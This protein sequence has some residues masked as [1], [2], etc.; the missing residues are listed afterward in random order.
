MRQGQAKGGSVRETLERICELQPQYSAEN[1]PEMQERGRLVRNN[2]R[3]EIDALRS[4]LTSALGPF[5]GDLLVEASDGIGRKTELPWVRFC[6]RNMSPNPTEGFYCV[7]H[8]STDGSAVH[9]T[10]GCGSSR[11]HKGSSVPLP[12]NELDAQ[13]DW[14]RRVVI[15]EFGTLV[16]FDHPADFGAR[17]PLPISF[18]RAT[19]ISHRVA[20]SDIRATDFGELFDQAALR[21]RP[22]Y[23]AQA[24]GR[25]LTDADQR[26]LEIATALNPLIRPSGRQGYGLSAPARRAVEKRAMEVASQF[27]H[28][29]GYAVRDTSGSSPF[30]F[31]ATLS[32]V[33]IKVEVKGTTSDRA[34]GILLTANE[35]ELHRTE[36]GNTALII[37]SSIRL[38]EKNGDY[39][40][41]GGTVEW[42]LGWDID[43]WLHEP[44][45]FRVTR[46]AMRKDLPIS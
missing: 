28:S 7:T 15:E 46:P 9:V 29:N 44:T 32:G 35:V 27:L 12:D 23:A 13:T 16:P 43:E 45:A 2:L 25:D 8:F 10:V 26:E 34:D 17:R 18:Q 39:S 33:R 21:L 1:T 3:A 20:Y 42:L 38:S 14:A 11:F 41:S 19:A 30:D 22:I 6:S 31:E 36:K 40:G 24:T 37:V 5:G 4:R